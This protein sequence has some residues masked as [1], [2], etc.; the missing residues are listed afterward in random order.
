[1]KSNIQ[2]E[3]IIAESGAVAFGYIDIG[4][5]QDSSILRLPLAIINGVEDG[6]ILYIQS[7]SDGNEL[8]GIAV[9]QRVIEYISP[10]KL[11]G[12]IIAVPI[13]NVFAFNYNQSENPIDK[14]KMNRCFSGKA[15]GTSSFRIAHRLFNSA[16]KQANLC[17]DLHQGDVS[18][19][20]DSVNVRVSGR[21]HLHKK[22]ME[23]AKVFGIGYILDEK[24]PNGQLA[25]VAPDIGIPTIDPE[26]GGCHGWDKISIEKGFKG[27]IN[28]LKY[29]NFIDGE[30]DIC[31]RQIVVKKLHSIICN[32]GG[33]IKYHASLYDIVEY[34]QPIADICDVF[35]RIIETI[36]APKKGVLWSTNLYPMTFGASI[37]GFLGIDISY[38]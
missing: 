18:P 9:I 8:N 11:K 33:F 4:E 21:H 34:R 29:Y 13:A 36:T 27:I 23:L 10:K 25:Q 2:I 17:I 20:V 26:L 14:R 30:P 31:Q 24:G 16:I 7:A 12:G 38:K 22:C 1:M 28:V 6:P 3:S 19:M 37:I 32:H 15:D 35:G 5:M